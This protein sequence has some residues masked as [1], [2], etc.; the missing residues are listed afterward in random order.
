ME[1]YCLYCIEIWTHEVIFNVTLEW[2]KWKGGEDNGNVII[3]FHAQ[4][5]VATRRNKCTAKGNYSIRIVDAGT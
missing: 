4:G 5:V 1:N 2:L 3:C